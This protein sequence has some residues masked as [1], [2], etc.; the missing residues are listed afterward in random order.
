[1]FFLQAFF[2]EAKCIFGN[3]L[4]HDEHR[5]EFETLLESCSRRL[6]DVDQ[7]EYYFVPSGQSGNLNYTN[8]FDWTE[9]VKRTVT[10]CCTIA[11]FF[12]V[13]LGNIC[14]CQM[15]SFSDSSYRR[16]V[17]GCRCY[18]SRYF[19]NNCKYMSRYI[20]SEFT[21]GH[22]RSHGQWQTRVHSHCLQLSQCKTA[23]NYA[24]EKLLDR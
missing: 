14:I 16:P 5:I 17:F 7:T 10:V 11:F 2:S 8:E 21:F 22:G 1:M 3:R 12:F 6:F 9:Q 24:I 23:N 13:F 19:T 4:I 20:S 15:I 18:S